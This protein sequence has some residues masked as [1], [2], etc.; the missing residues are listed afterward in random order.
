MEASQVQEFRDSTEFAFRKKIREAIWDGA[1][2]PA[3]HRAV[4]IAVVD[5]W[6]FHRNGPKGYIHPSRQKLADRARC[7]VRTVSTALGVFRRLGILIPVSGVKG[8]K[9]FATRY[10]VD[11]SAVLV[12]CDREDLVEAFLQFDTAQ[13]CP[14]DGPSYTAQNLQTVKE[15]RSTCRRP[16]ERPTKEKVHLSGKVTSHD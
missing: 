5:L 8:G 1:P 6:F 13:L 10:S 7:K 2:F 11:L 9:G 4:L 12:I 3:N 15:E 16:V 14:T